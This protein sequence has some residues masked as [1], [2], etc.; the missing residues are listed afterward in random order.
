MGNI[1]KKTRKKL[2]K[3]IEANCHR[4]T[5]FGEQ[6][7]MFVPYD[8]SPL[9]AIWKYLCIRNDDVI[10]GRFL[11]D[12]SKNIFLLGRDTVVSMLQNNCLFREHI[13]RSTNKLSIDLK[14]ATSFML[15]ITHG[16]KG[17]D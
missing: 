14:S 6:D 2:I 8:S 16:G 1:S 12:R 7:A 11:V 15:F 17:N 4:V 3:V 5:H 10:T 13:L 9:S